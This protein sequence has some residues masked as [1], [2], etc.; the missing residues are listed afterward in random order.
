MDLRRL[1]GQMNLGGA[2][3]QPMGDAPMVDTA[4]TVHVSSLALLKMLKHGTLFS[5]PKGERIS[6]CISFIPLPNSPNIFLFLFVSCIFPSSLHSNHFAGRRRHRRT[7]SK[8]WQWFFDARFA[9]RPLWLSNC[10]VLK[11][12][13]YKVLALSII[14]ESDVQN[15]YADLQTRFALFPRRSCWCSHGSYGS[16]VGR[17]Y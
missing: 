12:L 15:S 14:I 5:P 13:A 8:F 2:G 17:I 9:C 7:R 10:L 3:A 16:H 6:F 11:I 4:E 1:L